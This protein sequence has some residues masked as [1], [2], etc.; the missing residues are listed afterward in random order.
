MYN[1]FLMLELSGDPHQKR[2]SEMTSCQKNI[3]IFTAAL[4]TLLEELLLQLHNVLQSDPEEQL[5]TDNFQPPLTRIVC[6]FDD[7]LVHRL[8]EIDIHRVVSFGY[9]CVDK[10]VILPVMDA[11]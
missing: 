9:H 8:V 7:G 6:Y 2:V 10:L 3:L 5:F 1:C 4:M 11:I